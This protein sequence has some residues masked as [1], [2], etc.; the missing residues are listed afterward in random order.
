MEVKCEY[1]MTQ[2]QW[3]L[4]CV[5]LWQRLFVFVFVIVIVDKDDDVNIWHNPN[6]VLFV[7]HGHKPLIM[8][9]YGSSD[10]IADCITKVFY[11]VFVCVFEIFVVIVDND[12]D[13]MCRDMGMGRQW[14]HDIIRLQTA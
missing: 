4:V 1:S 2:L 10:N 6:R 3:G 8:A 14:H 12:D 7:R 13:R 11:L 5:C 9:T